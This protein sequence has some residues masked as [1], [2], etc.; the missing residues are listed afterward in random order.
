MPGLLSYY[1]LVKKE[2]KNF[3]N[4][5]IFNMLKYYKPWV[6]SM[7]ADKNII[8]ELPWMTFGAIE[9]LKQTAT[10]GMKVFEYGSGSSTIFWAPRVKEVY[11]VEHDE[12]WSKNVSAQM[13]QRNYSNVHLFLIQPEKRHTNNTVDVADPY[14]YGTDDDTWRDYSFEKYVRKIEEYADGY[15]DFVIVDGRA[16]PSC[17]AAA[18]KKVKTGGY[19]L[20]DNSERAYYFTQTKKLLPERQWQRQDFFGPVPGLTH[21]HQTSVFKKLV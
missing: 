19:L 2:R 6:A 13:K 20:V 17:I 11:S 9:F 18:V 4:A 5:S 16:R 1:K 12:Q 21:F 8:H 10:P 15:F 7:K 3:P 14:A